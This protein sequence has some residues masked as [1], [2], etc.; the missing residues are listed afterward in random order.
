MKLSGGSPVIHR[1]VI[2]NS[3][4]ALYLAHRQLERHMKD[5]VYS[6]GYREGFE[7]ALVSLAQMAGVGGEFEVSCKRL[8]STQMDLTIIGGRH[9]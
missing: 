5:D 9:E 4:R 2:L 7:V 8:A 6:S 3:L 1:N